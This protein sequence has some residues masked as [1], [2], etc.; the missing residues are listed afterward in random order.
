VK[1]NDPTNREEL[2]VS[3]AIAMVV[4]SLIVDC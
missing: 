4:L 2:T 1:K 3:S